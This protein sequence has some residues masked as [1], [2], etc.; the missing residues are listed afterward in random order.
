MHSRFVYQKRKRVAIT[1]TESLRISF[2]AVVEELE[3]R[4]T[5]PTLMQPDVG[6]EDKLHLDLRVSTQVLQ[7]MF[8][9]PDQGSAMLTT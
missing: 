1:D 2:V 9:Y 3:V 8:E 4:M 5:R 7:C 6:R